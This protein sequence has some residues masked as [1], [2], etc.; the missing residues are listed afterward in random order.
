M[1]DLLASMKTGEDPKIDAVS[2]SLA[3]RA[4]ELGYFSEFAKIVG[5]EKNAK[6]AKNLYNK[7]RKALAAGKETE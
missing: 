4:A 2:G 3:R 7:V 6:L 1:D 5:L